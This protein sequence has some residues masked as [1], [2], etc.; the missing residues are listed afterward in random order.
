MQTGSTGRRAPMDI[1]ERPFSPFPG[2]NLYSTLSFFEK[3][4][5]LSKKDTWLPREAYENEVVRIKAA[6]SRLENEKD[7][8]KDS[9]S[10]KKE[11]L[12]HGNFNS[13][14]TPRVNDKVEGLFR[15]ALREEK[16]RIRMEDDDMDFHDMKPGRDRIVRSKTIYPSLEALTWTNPG[17]EHNAI[18]EKDEI[19]EIG[20]SLKNIKLEKTDYFDKKTVLEI[21]SI[22]KNRRLLKKY[23]SKY[24]SKL[25]TLPPDPDL[26]VDALYSKDTPATLTNSFGVEVTFC[27]KKYGCISFEKIPMLP[28][29]SAGDTICLF[30]EAIITSKATTIVSLGNNMEGG[31]FKFPAYWLNHYLDEL[32]IHNDWVIS[33]GEKETLAEE[34]SVQS[35]NSEFPVITQR[36]LKAT[37]LST[38]EERTITHFHFEHWHDNRIAPSLDLLCIL[39]EHTNKLQQK[40]ETS[41]IIQSEDPCRGDE[42]IFLDVIISEFIRQRCS[43]ISPEQCSVNILDYLMKLRAP[44]PFAV[45]K[46]IFEV[47]ADLDLER[48]LS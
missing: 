26:T 39:I 33:C 8:L 17:D 2:E 7:S 24:L 46:Q 27:N 5:E 19:Q 15:E 14:S 6:I 11:E 28:S 35:F 44:L 16:D 47:V 31:K 1:V 4:V 37:S 42:F 20:D 45:F 41:L 25:A 12:N 43:G 13:T 48:I 34:V 32:C 30:W 9:V 38:G 10:M 23:Y 3:I 29:L 22:Y 21:D 18:S 40:C 36:V